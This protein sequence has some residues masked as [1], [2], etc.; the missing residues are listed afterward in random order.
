MRPL[1]GPTL[2]LLVAALAMPA[3]SAANCTVEHGPLLIDEGR[4][5]QAIR[6]FTCVIEAEPAGVEVTAAGLRPSCSWGSIRIASATTPGARLVNVGA[7]L[8]NR[9]ANRASRSSLAMNGRSCG[10][11]PVPK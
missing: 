3:Q 6:E 1:V 7:L 2:A 10:S 5:K 11:R 8:N 4:Y 9:K